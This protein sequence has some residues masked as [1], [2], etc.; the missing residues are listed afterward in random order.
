MKPERDRIEAKM[1]GRTQANPFGEQSNPKGFQRPQPSAGGCLS[2]CQEELKKVI[3][4]SLVR[5]NM[6]PKTSERLNSG[7]KTFSTSTSQYSVV[8]T[9]NCW[10]E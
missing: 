4:E 2:N 8:R 7:S 1:I 10:I 9:N 5:Q 6:F 3:K